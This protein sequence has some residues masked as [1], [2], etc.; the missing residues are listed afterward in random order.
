MAH[1]TGDSEK[2]LMTGL[3]TEVWAG[4]RES[5]VDVEAPGLKRQREEIILW[6]TR[7][8]AEPQEKGNLREAMV[9]EGLKHCRTDP[10]RETIPSH[11]LLLSPVCAFYWQNPNGKQKAKEPW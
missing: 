8:E 5:T 6:E 11:S 3:F 9:W 10:A 1:C 2:N 4:L 7:R